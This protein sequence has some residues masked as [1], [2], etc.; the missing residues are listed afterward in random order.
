MTESLYVAGVAAGGLG[1]LLIGMGLMTDGLK[2]AAGGTLRDILAMSTSSRQRALLSG[3]LITAIVQSSSA[4]TVATIGFVNAGLELADQVNAGTLAAPD[5]VY[6]ANGTMAT[7]AGLALGFALAGLGAEVQAV[8]VTHDFVSNPDAMRRLIA[9]TAL[10][11][12][13]LDPAIPAGLADS[14]RLR[15]R[16]E[17]FGSGYAH[18]TPAADRAVAVAREELGLELETTYTGKALAA[19]LDDLD[20]PEFASQTMLFWNTFNSRPLAAGETGAAARTRLP[21]EFLRYFD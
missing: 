11:L 14:V 12:R 21:D 6:V 9:K 8:R 10:L 15:C 13:R 18:T 19:L 2:I 3:V 17:F 4:V 7:A 5:R 1:L 16:D 20:R